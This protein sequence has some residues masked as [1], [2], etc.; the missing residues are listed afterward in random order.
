VLSSATAFGMRWSREINK[1]H[2][3]STMFNGTAARAWAFQK[4]LLSLM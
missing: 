3:Y 2:F 4:S 1:W